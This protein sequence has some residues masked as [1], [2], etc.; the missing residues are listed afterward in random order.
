[1]DGVALNWQGFY[2]FLD[3]VILVMGVPKESLDMKRRFSRE[4]I[5]L[6][7]LIGFLQ[8]VDALHDIGGLY[9]KV[10][11]NHDGCIINLQWIDQ[12]D[13]SLDET[14]LLHE[15]DSIFDGVPCHVEPFCHLR[16]AYAGVVLEG[17]QYHLVDAIE[18]FRLH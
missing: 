7:Y 6:E 2:P 3:E 8:F 13:I 15:L 14:E 12:G 18:F 1:M 16:Q 17:L 5:D 11:R 4:T 9:I 10:N